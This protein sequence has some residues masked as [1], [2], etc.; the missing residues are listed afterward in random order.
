MGFSEALLLWGTS[1]D[2]LAG[3]S[4]GAGFD[5]R[6]FCILNIKCAIIER[7]CT[8]LLR[9][10]FN[11]T[12]ENIEIERMMH[13]RGTTSEGRAVRTAAPISLSL[14]TSAHAGVAIRNPCKP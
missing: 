3:I 12:P 8:A 9:L 7:T 1:E 10:K 13:Y 5:L 11:S 14:R 4:K 2:I 6:P